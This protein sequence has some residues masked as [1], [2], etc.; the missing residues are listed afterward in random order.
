MIPIQGRV[1]AAVRTTVC[2]VYRLRRHPGTDLG[3]DPAARIWPPRSRR[4]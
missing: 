4:A 3:A 1:S 2:R